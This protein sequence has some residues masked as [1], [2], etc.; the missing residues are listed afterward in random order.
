MT[1]PSDVLS[2]TNIFKSGEFKSSTIRSVGA[3]WDGGGS[4]VATSKKMYV[5]VPVAMEI[6][7]WIVF[8]D[9]S[10]TCTIDI[11]Q[12]LLAS[13]PPTVSNTICNSN[14]PGTTAG[15]FASLIV[16]TGGVLGFAT[17]LN[18]S[19]IPIIPAGSSLVFNVKTN[20]NAT[21]LRAELICR[22]GS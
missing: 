10:A 20:D 2:G 1:A 16:P 13:A 5:Y 11:W 19:G 6:L 21:E 3:F 7:G 12:T 17:S 4:A 22:C 9:V 18:V 8:T 14:Y 15:T